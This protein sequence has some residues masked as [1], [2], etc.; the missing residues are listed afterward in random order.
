LTVTLVA[1]G[2]GPPSL[3]VAVP[4]KTLKKSSVLN[5]ATGPSTRLTVS[6]GIFY[7]P[8]WLVQMEGQDDFLRMAERGHHIHWSLS[9]VIGRPNRARSNG[10]RD[11]QPDQPQIAS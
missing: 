7:C 1:Q 3:D 5:V 6:W 4:L 9:F 8:S 11:Q 2:M 10:T